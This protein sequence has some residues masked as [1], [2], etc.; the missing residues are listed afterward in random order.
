M[1][2]KIRYTTDT[3]K[4]Y[5]LFSGA[6]LERNLKKSRR[7]LAL[8]MVAMH[9]ILVF[10]A[11]VIAQVHGEQQ[12]P[13]Y[14]LPCSRSDPELNSCI[15]NSFNHLRTYVVNGLKDLD[16]PPLDPLNIKEMA[17]ENNAGAVQV[18]ALFT[19]I[20]VK[21]GSNY[22]IKDVRADINKYR[23]DV[24]VTIPRVETRG[25]YEII[26]RVLLLPV[27][28]SGEFWTEFLNISAI[29]KLYG[30]EV[31][32]DGEKYM[33]IDKIFLDFNMKNARF[34]VKDNINNGNVLG[35]AINQFLNSNAHELVQEMRPAASQSIA[36]LAKQ[37]INSA[38]NRIPLR[39]WLLD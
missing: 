30:R 31:E 28:S 13:E 9:H 17:M 27:Q 8:K 32:R 24:S 15:R 38:F 29:G 18:K 20:L 1:Q 34:K 25:K 21:G 6:L 7:K 3:L 14:I 22:T 35:E 12:T 2:C 16:V 4:I 37:L 10:V 33:N 36:K 11:V 39:V 23:I 26:G 5:R 19:D